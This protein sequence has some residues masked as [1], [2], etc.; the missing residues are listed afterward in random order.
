M[1]RHPIHP[2]TVVRSHL[3]TE[4]TNFTPGTSREGS[5]EIFLQRINYMTEQIHG[6]Y[7]GN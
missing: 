6:T 4:E 7:C 5:P 1:Q 3:S 2:K